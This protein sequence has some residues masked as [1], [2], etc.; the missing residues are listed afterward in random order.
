VEQ[1]PGLVV[2]GEASRAEELRD[3]MQALSPDLVLVDWELPG[4]PP[5]EFLADLKTANHDCRVIVLSQDPGCI[6]GTALANADACLSKAEPPD[7]F[8]ATL[9]GLLAGEPGEVTG[10]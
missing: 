3:K 9:M 7:R 5:V 1:Q 6:P 8:L 2:V 10:R 4:G